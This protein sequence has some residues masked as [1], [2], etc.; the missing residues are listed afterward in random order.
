M[1]GQANV[2][3]TSY[4][5]ILLHRVLYCTCSLDNQQIKCVSNLLTNNFATQSTVCMLDIQQV[6]CVSNQIQSTVATPLNNGPRILPF[7]G[8]GGGKQEEDRHC[9]GGTEKGKPRGAQKLLFQVEHLKGGMGLCEQNYPSMR[10][11]KVK[12][13]Q[14]IRSPNYEAIRVM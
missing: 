11:W 8:D 2:R 4:L 14:L 13:I 6:K 9:S 5:T 12:Y 10:L 7:S 1:A 3:A